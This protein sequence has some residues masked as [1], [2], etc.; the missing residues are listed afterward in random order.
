[1][2]YL[3]LLV[4]WLNHTKNESVIR[5][6]NHTMTIL[7]SPSFHQ[8]T[9]QNSVLKLSSQFPIQHLMN[10]L[11]FVATKHKETID[12]IERLHPTTGMLTVMHPSATVIDFKP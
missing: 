12:I 10:I 7:D 11:D 1:M 4:H 5:T 3:G 8:V 2:L 9:I 6:D